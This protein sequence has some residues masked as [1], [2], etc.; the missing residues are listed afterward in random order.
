M[1]RI[2]SGVNAC[3]YHHV[4]FDVINKRYSA[5]SPAENAERFSESLSDSVFI[6]ISALLR[7]LRSGFL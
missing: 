7:V 3:C 6:D 4:P 1:A 2:A 5:A